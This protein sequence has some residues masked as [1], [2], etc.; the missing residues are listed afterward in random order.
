MSYLWQ[1]YFPRLSFMAPKVGPSFYGYRQVYIESFY[2]SFGSLSVDY[3]LVVYDVLQLAVAVGLAALYTTVVVRWRV[4][5]AN[6]PV[7]AVGIMLP[8]RAHGAPAHRQLQLA[9]HLERSCADR[10]LSLPAIALYGAAAAWVCS[11][12]PRRAGLLVA[13][14]LIG[15]S[16]LL[17]VG[18]VGLSLERFYV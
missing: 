3:R 18:G 14:V 9:A 17:A 16:A 1:F 6:W 4:V 10:A 7:V 13:A 15:A 2:G 8:R 5:L 11:S 12:L